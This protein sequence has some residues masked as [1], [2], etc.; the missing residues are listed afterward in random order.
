VVFALPYLP[1]IIVLNQLII[2]YN[3]SRA[4]SIVFNDNVI[5]NINELDNIVCDK[6]NGD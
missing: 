2:D 4:P 5:Y 6:N 1:E 3:V